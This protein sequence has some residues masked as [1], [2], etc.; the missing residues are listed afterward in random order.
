MSHSNS[1]RLVSD[2]LEMAIAQRGDVHRVI[3][4]SDRSKPYASNEY[5][6][7]I[8]S[9]GIVSS[10]S[11]KGDC[12]D[13]APMVSFYHSLKTEW[14][15]FEDYRNHNETRASIFNYIELF[16]NCK[17]RH[18]ALNYLSPD[19]YEKRPSIH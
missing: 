4:H 5:Q 18:S 16:Y 9:H 8:K 15:V 19:N 2:A 6:Q 10:M 14:V 11:S 17:R 1:A 13:N 7:L 3:L 12:W